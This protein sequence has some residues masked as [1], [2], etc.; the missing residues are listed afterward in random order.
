MQTNNN[1]DV[2]FSAALRLIDMIPRIYGEAAA[3]YVERLADTLETEGYAADARV[4]RAKARWLRGESVAI[5]VQ[6]GEKEASR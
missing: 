6:D 1:T 4:V 5:A 2:K 3:C